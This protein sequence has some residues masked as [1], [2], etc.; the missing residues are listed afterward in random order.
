M[1]IGYTW[2]KIAST[3]KQKEVIQPG[4]V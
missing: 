4:T 1:I 3:I 2:I